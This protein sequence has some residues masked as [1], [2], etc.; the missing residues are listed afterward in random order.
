MHNDN[1]MKHTQPLPTARGIRRACSKEL[2]RARKK[3]GGG[4]IAPD[5]VEQ[6]DQVYYKKVMLNLPFIA[7][8]SSNR[9]LLANWF[10]ENVCGEIAELWSVEPKVLAKAF[11]ESFGG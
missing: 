2:Y 7:E 3:L 10:E 8:N 4:Y 11:R 9:K 5:L 6:A 1:K